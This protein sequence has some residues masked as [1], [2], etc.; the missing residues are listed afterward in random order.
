MA[1]VDDLPGLGGGLLGLVVRARVGVE[2]DPVA[3]RAA[4]ELVHGQPQRLAPDV[5][6]RD[7]DPAHHR[8]DSAPRAD[9][10]EVAE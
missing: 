6:E 2:P 9:V 8:A 4:E 7:V 1:R 3:H 5:P 10:G